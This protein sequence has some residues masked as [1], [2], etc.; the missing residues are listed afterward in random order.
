[1]SVHKLAITATGLLVVGL[2]PAGF[3]LF[4]MSELAR[5][6]PGTA[7]AAGADQSEPAQ[8]Q[9]KTEQA[10]APLPQG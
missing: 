7:A 4:A 9:P 5:A 1:M 8:E 3:G 10:A 2:V 6:K